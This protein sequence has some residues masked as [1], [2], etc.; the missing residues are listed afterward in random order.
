[1][2]VGECW[3]N[4]LEEEVA[5]LQCFECIFQSILNIAIR[6]AGIAVF[7]MLIIGGFQYLTSG[8][9]PKATESAKNTLTYAILGLALLLGS[10]LIL[11]FIKEFTGVD[12]TQFVI[13]K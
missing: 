3:K 11:L 7:I 12:V 2:A 6:L 5:A 9:D 13:P 8:G 4:C 1:M 10:W